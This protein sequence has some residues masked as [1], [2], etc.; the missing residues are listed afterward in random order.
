[1]EVT[2]P[3]PEYEHACLEAVSRVLLN[4][5]QLDDNTKVDA[6]GLVVDRGHRS[7]VAWYERF[8]EPRKE[9]WRL[10][11]DMFSGE[12]PHGEAEDPEGVADQMLVWVLG[13]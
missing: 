1:M 13:G 10:Y 4:R 7:I 6:V 3:S 8:G 12:M 5:R 9:T 11:E 2:R